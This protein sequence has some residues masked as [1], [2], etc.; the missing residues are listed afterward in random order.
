MR[1][2]ARGLGALALGASLAL[3]AAPLL[4]GCGRSEPARSAAP[5]LAPEPPTASRAES[6][7][8]RSRAAQRASPGIEVEGEVGGLDPEAV[9]KAVRAAERDIDRCW[10]QGVARN[11]LVAGNIQ[12]VL[13]IG[14]D[15]RPVHGFVEQSTLGEGQMERCMLEALS[16]RS[17]PKPV[18]GKVGV[19]RTR[20]SFDLAKDAR[21]P[22][23][24]PSAQAASALSGAADEIA[25][26]KKGLSASFTATVYVKQVELP[27]P[28][29]ADGDAGSDAG[30]DAADAGPTW[31]G[32]ALGVGVAAPDEA[33]WAAVGCLERALSR[34]VYPAPGSW[35]AK[36]T[37]S[38]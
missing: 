10:E 18:G 21:A 20:F 13:G 8:P 16:A 30:E 14:R 3:T 17:F 28:P 29:A 35:P 4:P 9:D 37:F 6:D 1:S 32:A 12:L 23:S 11:E 31:V 27:P 36:V 26:C 15:G 34:A 5:D 24:W 19:V 22:V 38:L 7:E 33:A 2:A 25:A